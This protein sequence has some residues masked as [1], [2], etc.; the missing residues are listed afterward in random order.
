MES[1]KASAK[2]K[3]IGRIVK[4]YCQNCRTAV[5][6]SKLACSIYTCCE[7][8]KTSKAKQSVGSE[9]SFLRG[10]GTDAP[11]VV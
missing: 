7:I 1:L 9:E 5:K 8:T 3:D 6:S 10:Q 2:S 11:K 4:R